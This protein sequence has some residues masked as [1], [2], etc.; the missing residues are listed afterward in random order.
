MNAYV[1]VYRQPLKDDAW[2]KTWDEASEVPGLKKYLRRY[3]RRF[4]KSKKGIGRFYDWGDDPSFF[5][6]EEFLGDVRKASWGVCRPNVRCKLEKGDFIVFFCAQQ[7]EDDKDLWKYYYIGL[8][9]VRDRIDR[10]LIW[11]DPNLKG[12]K[13]FYNLLVNSKGRQK[14]FIHKYH[15]D[16]WEKRAEAPYV[17][18]AK[19]KTHFNLTDPLLVAKYRVGDG[20]WKG[21]IMETWFLSDADVRE[22]YSLIPK[23]TK[24][25][26]LRT[27]D[28]GYDHAPM[29]LE[30][31][32][33]EE[34]KQRLRDKYQITQIRGE[35][36]ELA[37]NAKE[38]QLK[39]LRRKLLK[40][41]REIADQ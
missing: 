10:R 30:Q 14:E 4:Q 32:T 25:K 29:N 23:R 40:I 34:E 20:A 12:Y 21:N 35:L 2:Q 37:N 11:E 5:A 27:S 13:R 19:N 15:D 24:Y 22:I 26:K 16:D 17:V 6:A 3:K 7:Q 8:G 38:K 28:Q 36:K 41:S 9:T 39:R 33:I 31:L 18:F 1:C